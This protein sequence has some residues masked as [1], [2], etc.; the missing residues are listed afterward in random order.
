VLV[1]KSKIDDVL[2][3]LKTYDTLSVDTETTGLKPY[4]GDRMFSLIIGT[5]KYAYYFNFIRYP[6]MPLEQVCTERELRKLRKFFEDG[7][8][9]WILQNAKFDMHHMW[10]FG[11]ELAGEV[12][13]TMIMHRLVNNLAWKF[14]LD[15]LCKYYDVDT[16]KMD[17]VKE[18]IKEHKLYEDGDS[19]KPQYHKV[20]IE[21]MQPYAEAD[22]MATFQVYEKQ[23]KQLSELYKDQVELF[24]EKTRKPDAVPTSNIGNVIKMEMEMTQCLFDVERTGLLVDEEW[25]GNARSLV[26]RHSD[27]LREEF[28]EI[29]GEEFVNSWQS[30]HEAFEKVGVDLPETATVSAKTGNTN[31]KFDTSAQILGDIDHKLA[32]LVLGIRDAEK[33]SRTYFGSYLRFADPE[34]R[35]HADF[36]SGGT[37]TGRMSCADPNLQNIKKLDEGEADDSAF[38][39]R[40]SFI[41]SEGFCFFMPD[42]DQ[43]EYRIMIDYAGEHQIIQKVLDGMDVHQATADQMGVDRK[44]AKTINFGQI[45]GQGIDRLAKMLGRHPEEVKRLREEYHRQ[46]PMVKKF[47]W[48]VRSR[49]EKFKQIRNWLGRVYYHDGKNTK[50]YQLVNHLIQGSAADAMKVG[51]IDCW[52]FLS[53]GEYK[54]R[55]VSTIHDE[56]VFEI[57]ESELD[58]CPKL[59]SIMEKAYPH[60]FVPLTVGP[61]FSWYSLHDK[62]EGYPCLP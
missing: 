8:K 25:V 39:V 41:P 22:V 27:K 30:I 9:R 12:W 36:K 35:I 44:A 46:L 6:E 2:E 17:V 20:P 60:D 26:D 7:T 19:S 31:R 37:R 55:L 43:M 15:E 38:P 53:K 21:L 56:L 23:K 58:I 51:M 34:G 57:H 1:L 49:A 32:R 14:S 45:Y 4:L 28:K 42:Y 11:I 33:N 48:G 47:V 13:D 5:G 3:D 54:S 61:Q 24:R 62:E 10:Q 16:Q 40:K 52:K 59:V 50:S 18:F 29:C